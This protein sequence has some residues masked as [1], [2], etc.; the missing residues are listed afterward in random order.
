MSDKSKLEIIDTLLQDSMI[1]TGAT[2]SDT[3]TIT[4]NNYDFA[5]PS[6]NY[7][8]TIT[9]TSGAAQPVYTMGPS[10]YTIAGDTGYNSF[11]WGDPQEWIDSFPEWQRVQDMCS[12]Y[13]GLEIAL[14][15]FR[16]VYT[17]VKDDYDNP[18]DKE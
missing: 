5:S 3:Y 6:I 16:T 11:N 7:N 13:P 18:K 4:L 1:A 15:N 8:D 17:L 10:S 9:I 2:G 14:R 12:K